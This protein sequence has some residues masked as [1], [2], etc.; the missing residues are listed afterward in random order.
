MQ[1]GADATIGL[2]ISLALL[3]QSLPAHLSKNL[4]NNF[5]IWNG[6]GPVVGVG[7]LLMDA[8]VDAAT[9]ADVDLTDRI[10]RAA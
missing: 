5:P 8:E 7:V 4:K 3:H 9:V 10:V 1:N 6:S 2:R